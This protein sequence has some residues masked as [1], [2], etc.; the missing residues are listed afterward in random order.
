MQSE[1]DLLIKKLVEELEEENLALFI[2]AG[3]STAAGFVN[4]KGLLKSLAENLNLDID[5]EHDLINIAQYYVNKNNRPCL[6]QEIIKKLAQ[7]REPTENHK[8]LSRL[9]I[10]IF[11]TTNYDRLIE[12]ALENSGKI[13]DVK[14]CI[15]H[16]LTTMPQRDA[17]LYKMHGD[18]E[19]LGDATITKDE[20]EKYAIK[21]AP[22]VTA[23]SG[24]LVSK[25]FL[26]LGF[27]FTDP[28]LD[29]IMSR[30]RISFTDKQRQHYCILKK[31]C[32]KNFDDTEDFKY[33]SIKQELQVGDLKRFNIKALLVDEYSD[34]TNILKRTEKLY[35]RKTVFLSGS[36]HKYDTWS[37]RDIESFLYELGSKLIESG[38]K[39]SSGLGLGISN[40]FISGAI[41]SVYEKH[42]GKVDAYIN[43]KPFPQYIED[44]E[45]NQKIKTKYRHEILGSAGI[46]LFFMG[47][48]LVGDDICLADGMEKEFCIAHELGLAI[49]PIGCSG[50]MAKALWDRVM[51]D[52]STYYKD[53]RIIDAIGELGMEVEKPDQL[54]S[55]ILN[56]VDLM[57][58]E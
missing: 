38:Y 8:I 5:K 47:N 43:M 51:G 9:P 1:Q 39:I 54:I 32:K 26:F 52:I 11:W 3:L 31:C 57:S 12:N 4:W 35:K 14:Y 23:L 21:M 46:A 36:A 20:Y 40:A 44:P 53:K 37:Q 49:I 29:Y 50:Y 7:I 2:G 56:I 19:N 41:K 6:S 33:A 22:Y 18:C 16:L 27:S 28:N 34:I 30:V 25:T 17:I 10:K 42:N 15:E 24:D 55:K 58:K 45:I 13:V 48:K